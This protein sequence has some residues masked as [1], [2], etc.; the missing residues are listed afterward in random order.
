MMDG[1]ARMINIPS[2]PLIVLPRAFIGP[3]GSDSSPR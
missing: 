3:R 1:G 2:V